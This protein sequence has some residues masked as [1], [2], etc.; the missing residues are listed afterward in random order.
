MIAQ[1]S[2]GCL[3]H[4]DR[5]HARQAQ[6]LLKRR[7]QP[8]RQPRAVRN[9]LALVALAARAR[10]RTE[11]AHASFQ[12]SMLQL[13]RRSTHHRIGELRLR[14]HKAPGQQLLGTSEL[15]SLGFEFPA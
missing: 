3:S 4:R 6:Q 11:Q 14:Q 8:R 10:T 12:K 15:Y 7:A 9:R 2:N 1:L 5:P 13:Q